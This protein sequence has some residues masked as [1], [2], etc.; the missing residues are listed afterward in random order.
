MG[1]YFLIEAHVVYVDRFLY[2]RLR[3]VHKK[4]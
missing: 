4:E 1:A 2:H 3:N